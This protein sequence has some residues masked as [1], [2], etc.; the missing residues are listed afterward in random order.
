MG[1]ESSSKTSKIVD[2]L[3]SSRISKSNAKGV[4]ING[5]GSFI[6][7]KEMERRDLTSRFKCIFGI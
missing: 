6:A 5:D 2:V 4:F 3:L 7:A 1:I